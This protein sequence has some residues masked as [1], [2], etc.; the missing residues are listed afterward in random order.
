MLI[1]WNR[2][3]GGGETDFIS[4]QGGGG[5]GGFAFYNYDNTGVMSQ[6]LSIQANGSIGIGTANT[7]GYKLAVK[8]SIVA[9]SVK[10]QLMDPWPDYVFEKSY[11]RLSLSELECYVSTEKHLPEM[12]SA[13]AVLKDGIDLGDMNVKLLKKIEELTLY[14]IEQNKQIEILKDKVNKL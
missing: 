14:L 13:Q 3:A 11:K 2:S 10:V 9:T 5:I 6:L 12:P 1:G 4:N 7:N 8:G